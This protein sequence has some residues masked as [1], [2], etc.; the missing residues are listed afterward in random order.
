MN[1]ILAID[2]TRKWDWRR[3]RP[4]PRSGVTR[5][6]DHCGTAHEVH[7]TIEFEGR[8]L[9]V[10]TTCARDLLGRQG[11]VTSGALAKAMLARELIAL[12][13][14]LAQQIP[15]DVDDAQ[16]WR[17]V[18]SLAAQQEEVQRKNWHALQTHTFCAWLALRKATNPG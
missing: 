11:T 14:R 15:Q 2:D 16:A 4:I 5:P 13:N 12:G 18:I 9:V 10:G 6:C 7:V 3:Q 8:Q 17:L 1:R